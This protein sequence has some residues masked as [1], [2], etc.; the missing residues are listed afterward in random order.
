[1]KIAAEAARIPHSAQSENRSPAGL[2]H[3]LAGARER[4]CA[5]RGRAA[6]RNHRSI[7]FGKPCNA[8]L[9]TTRAPE[10]P[11]WNLRGFRPAARPTY[12]AESV[13]AQAPRQVT[14]TSA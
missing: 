2:H 11:A 3:P 5:N 8:T 12:A 10:L 1:M 6:R 4:E 7:D 14:E 9:W 13:I